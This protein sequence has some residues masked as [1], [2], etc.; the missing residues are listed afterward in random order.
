MSPARILLVDDD[1]TLSQ[2]IAREL[3]HT[4]HE[5]ERFAS[6]EGVLE[7]VRLRPP[8]AILLDLR[9]PG[10][11]G[12]ELLRALRAADAQ[13]QVVVFSGHGSVE[14]AVEAMRLGAFDFLTKPVQLDV[15]EQTLRRAIETNALLIANQRLRRA[16]S[17]GRTKDLLGDSAP[18]AELRRLI[19]RV[20]TSDSHVLI[21]G[22]NGTGKELV[23]RQLHER[24]ARAEQPFVVVHCGAMPSSLV[25]SELFGHERGAFTGADR[26]RTGL[27]EAAQGGVLFLDEI[28]ELPLDLQ[29]VLLRALQFGE[30]RPVGGASTR[31][32]DVRVLAATNRDLLARVRSGH[33][34][35]DLYY[36]I[37]A[38]VIEV[39]ALRDRAADLP[40]LARACL[41]Q[42]AARAGR[43]LTFTPQALA[44]LAD[45][46]WPG[47]VRELENA[48]ERL[49]VLVPSESVDAAD[50]ERFVLVRPAATVEL[51]TL[52]LHGLETMAI[53]EA[54]HRFGGDKRS[55]AS[56][57][58]IALKTL[59]NKLERLRDPGS[60][61]PTST[62]T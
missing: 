1:T 27:F 4:G 39:P 25:E 52:H 60:T 40:D 45:H 51:P 18:M 15:L 62:R 2:V 35:E 43:S 9:L 34:R 31:S 50:V 48:C 53:R 46:A 30:I 23:A 5:V 38:L 10:I 13:V 6:A 11:S 37:A 57:L 36:R 8:Q 3:G 26:R 24:S 44:R 14:Q 47:N 41:A 20:A 33:F 58:G 59:Y 42:S 56:T 19:V 16:A 32:V 12:M 55:A 61:G 28:G 49:A 22:E 21:Q 29:P 54:M 7:A 17:G